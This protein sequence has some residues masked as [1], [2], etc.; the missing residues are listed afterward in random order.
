[1]NWG[2]GIIIGMAIFVV[3]IVG[4]CIYMIASPTDAFDHQYYEKGLSFNQDY[5][6]E[7]QVT[8]DHAQPQI[9]IEDHQ[10]KFVFSQPAKG[11]IKFMRPS[12]TSK[13]RV[14]S[15]NSAK[16]LA[17]SVPLESF[18]AG[19]WQLVFEWTSNHKA[20]LYQQEIYIK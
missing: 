12:S 1:M 4:M 19:K 13:D 3:F 9:E 17:S 5:N 2:K 15:I 7:E 11:T 8:K 16:G 10:I 20:Y 6:R 14:Y 18:A